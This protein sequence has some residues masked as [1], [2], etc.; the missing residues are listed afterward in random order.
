MEEKLIE[1]EALL[2]Q[3]RNELKA[4]QKELKEIERKCKMSEA[5]VEQR[6]YKVQEL[7][8]AIRDYENCLHG[9]YSERKSVIAGKHY[10][11]HPL[12]KSYQEQLDSVNLSDVRRYLDCIVSKIKS[13]QSDDFCITG[14]GVWV[15]PDF[16]SGLF[17]DQE[18][19]IKLCIRIIGSGNLRNN[20][21]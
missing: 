20:F 10:L 11:P 1:V 16:H 15:H 8:N 2:Q 18:M 9:Y 14:F 4:N 5:L 6:L 19:F 13:A 12:F 3:S 17:P 7:R 21:F